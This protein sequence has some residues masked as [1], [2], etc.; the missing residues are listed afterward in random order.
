MA[1]KNCTL[2]ANIVLITL[3]TDQQFSGVFALLTGDSI[4]RFMTEVKGTDLWCYPGKDIDYIRRQLKN[5][6]HIL[7]KFSLIVIHI[8]TNNIHKNSTSHI[9]QDFCALLAAIREICNADVAFSC[10]LPRPRD[11]KRTANKIQEINKWLQNWS[12]ANQCLCLRS[13]NFA[14]KHVDVV[15]R[16]DGL[17]LNDEGIRRFTDFL[18]HQLAPS[19]LKARLAAWRG[20]QDNAG[21]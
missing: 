10:I 15:Y 6:S 17:H 19:V 7:H 2:S 11:D 4:L 12:E 18:N 1:F 21:Q 9:K 20:G 13:Y 8:G 16:R 5:N 3:V 14:R